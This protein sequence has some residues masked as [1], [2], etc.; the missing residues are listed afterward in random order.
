MPWNPCLLPVFDGVQQ[1]RDSPA[2]R[3]LQQRGEP[4]H[5]SRSLS[6]LRPYRQTSRV[7]NHQRGWPVKLTAGSPL[8]MGRRMYSTS[9]EFPSQAERWS[10]VRPS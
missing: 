6:L 9:L 5:A 1:G 4:Q 7:P 8:F 3:H 10:A 2:I